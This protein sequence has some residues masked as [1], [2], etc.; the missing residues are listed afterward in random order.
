[1]VDKENKMDPD[2]RRMK[3]DRSQPFSY[4]VDKLRADMAE[5]GWLP[6]DLAKVAGVA[7]P[8]VHRFLDGE[9]QTAR[10]LKKLAHALGYTTR[11]YL[12]RSKEAVSA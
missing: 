7:D 11:R 1:M 12:I 2:C 3:T 5:R 4:D 9:F 10:T 8:T 6:T